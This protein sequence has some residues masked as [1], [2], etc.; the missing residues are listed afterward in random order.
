M[1]NYKH[2][3]VLVYFRNM[4]AGMVWNLIRAGS[5]ELGLRV[6]S[7]LIEYEAIHR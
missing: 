4:F 3:L 6:S 1:V 7:G 2:E 5:T